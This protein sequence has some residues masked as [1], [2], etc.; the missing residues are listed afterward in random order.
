MRDPFVASASAFFGSP[1]DIL[2][3]DQLGQGPLLLCLFKTKVFSVEKNEPFTL[4]PSLPEKSIKQ[5]IF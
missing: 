3:R 5:A 1:L 4:L 2:M